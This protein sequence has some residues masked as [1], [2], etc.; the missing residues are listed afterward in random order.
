MIFRKRAPDLQLLFFYI[1][2]AVPL[3]YVHDDPVLSRTVRFLVLFLVLLLILFTASLRNKVI[4]NYRRLP[5]AGR[6]ALALISV[7]M[8]GSLLKS[9]DGINTALLGL[10]PEYLGLFSWFAFGVL[11]L[12]LADRLHEYL[13]KRGTLVFF[14]SVMIGSLYIDRYFIKYG[15]RVSGLLLQATSMGVYAALGCVIGLWHLRTAKNRS[16]QVLAG[17]L[18]VLSLVAVLLTQSRVGYLGLAIVCSMLVVHLLAEHRKMIALIAAVVVLAVAV[19]PRLIPNYFERFDD[20]T[21]SIGISYR[22]DLYATSVRDLVS[23]NLLLGNGPS[24][25]PV[26]INN[27][28]LVPEDIQK[29]LRTGDIFLSSHNLYLDMGYFFGLVAAIALLLLSIHALIVG[30]RHTSVELEQMLL[31][32]LLLLN[33]LI[34]VPSLELTS[35]TVILTLA[36]YGSGSET[37]RNN[38]G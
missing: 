21:V 13:L 34:N 26:A 12:L 22:L 33:A 1:F 5:S 31:Y 2:L 25:L 30:L 9:Q 24:S 18:I 7:L 14:L 20:S 6:L 16:G 36:I 15:M 29:S 37:S 3:V 23:H 4:E 17:A 11:A 27:E 28:N 10:T 38:H 19:L 35:L 32:I 8:I